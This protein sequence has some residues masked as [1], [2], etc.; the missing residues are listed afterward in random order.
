MKR[1]DP[2]G[3][4][5]SVLAMRQVFAALEKNEAAFLRGA[6]LERLDPR[7]RAWRQAARDGFETVWPRALSQGLARQP[8]EAAALYLLCL[9]AVLRANGLNPPA[10]AL[11][12]HPALEALA[13]EAA[14]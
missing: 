8:D 12:E 10:G 5:P 4:D 2:Y 9:G 13:R 7:L 14:S 3:A 11:P 6:G 1:D